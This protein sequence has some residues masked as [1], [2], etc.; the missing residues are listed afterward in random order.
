MS[1]PIHDHAKRRSRRPQGGGYRDALPQQLRDLPPTLTVEEAARLFRIGRNQAYEAVAAGT[2]PAI[3]V[4][5]RWVIPTV[6]V[7]R[8]LGV[9]AEDERLGVTR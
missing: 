7:L 6:R 3:R 5:R 8:M 1:P 9:D 2:L 4:G